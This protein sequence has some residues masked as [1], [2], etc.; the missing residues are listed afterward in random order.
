MTSVLDEKRRIVLPK[1]LAEEL[2]LVEG[3]R[4]SFTRDKGGVVVR[5][6]EGTGDS[7]R[8]MM[9]WD[10]KRTSK[11]KPVREGEVKEVWKTH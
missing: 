10:P 8:E 3:S 11:P 4:V 1:D 2:G 9:S 7:L 5:K 6:V